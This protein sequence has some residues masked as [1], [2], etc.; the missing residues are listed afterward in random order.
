[1]A[2]PEVTNEQLAQLCAELETTNSTS[3]FNGGRAG[4]GRAVILTA[5]AEP[6]LLDQPPPPTSLHFTLR[7]P[8][9]P[10]RAAGLCLKSENVAGVQALEAPEAPVSFPFQTV[11]V[12]SAVGAGRARVVGGAVGAAAQQRVPAGLPPH[13]AAV[14]PSQ[15]SNRQADL[16]AMRRKYA[17]EFQT[18]DVRADGELAAA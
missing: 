18:V 14:F 17:A 9:A 4:A 5:V 7:P 10:H 2:Q 11:A 12:E 15:T 3:R 1:M 16:L 6:A 8:T 13:T